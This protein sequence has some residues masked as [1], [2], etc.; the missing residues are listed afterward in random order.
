MAVSSLTTS[1]S[2]SWTGSGKRWSPT[3]WESTSQP[4][5]PDWLSTK[6]TDDRQK[7]VLQTQSLNDGRASHVF[8]KIMPFPSPRG[9]TAVSRIQMKCRLWPSNRKEVNLSGA[10]THS[11]GYT[12]LY[13]AI[14]KWGGGIQLTTQKSCQAPGL[15][16]DSLLSP[17]FKC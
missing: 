1:V 14:Q 15:W 16:P 13:R 3:H 6:L 17:V 5:N 9:I 8:I 4:A 11:S 2:I 12:Y 10:Q 7:Q